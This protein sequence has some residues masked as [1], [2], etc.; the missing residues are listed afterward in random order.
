MQF[1]LF[2]HRRFVDACSTVNVLGKSADTSKVVDFFFPSNLEK[3][4]S[5]LGKN[6]LR[7]PTQWVCWNQNYPKLLALKI[8]QK[9]FHGLNCLNTWPCDCFLQVFRPLLAVYRSPLPCCIPVMLIGIFDEIPAIFFFQQD[10]E[11]LE[12][13][14]TSVIPTEVIFKKDGSE[15][16]LSSKGIYIL[17]NFTLIYGSLQN[18]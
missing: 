7:V 3:V 1:L 8:L 15:Y 2:L 16:T 12:S 5:A 4:G 18:C 13:K 6:S 9:M 14:C 11:N 10:T 17:I